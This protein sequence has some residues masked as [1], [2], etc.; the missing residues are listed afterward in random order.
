MHSLKKLLGLLLL[1]AAVVHAQS[2]TIDLRS[3]GS[4][5]IFIVDGWKVNTSEFGD[6]IILNLESLTDE[7]ANA[8]LT[9][10][11]PEQDRFSTKGKLKTQVEA[12][13]LP[14]EQGSVERKSVPRELNTRAGYGYYCNFTDPE[15]VGKPPQKG[16]FK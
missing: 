11:F 8:A 4:L 7:N 2:G 13:G 6:R 14:Y 9:I 12:N 10:T 5:E 1:S 15:L 16:N 3:R